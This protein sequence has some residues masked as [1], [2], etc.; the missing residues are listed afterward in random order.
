MK[1][2]KKTIFFLITAAFLV[3]AGGAYALEP[4]ALLGE[5]RYFV[6]SERSLVRA[7]F[8]SRHEFDGGFTSDLTRGELWAL[9]KWFDVSVQ[10]IPFYQINTSHEE[11]SSS[12]TEQTSTSTE[13]STT[14]QDAT[15]EDSSQT[16][17]REHTP[18]NQQSWGVELVR[19]T[20]VPSAPEE[21]ER[22]VAVAVLDTGVEQTHPDIAGRVQQCIDFTRSSIVTNN[23]DDDN[24]HGTHIAGILAGTGGADGEGV[25]GVAPHADIFAYKVCRSDGSC[26]ADDVSAGI[27][28]GIENGADI[29]VLGLGGADK[30]SLV[31]DALRLAEENNVL[32][33]ASAGN[34][35]ADDEGIGYPA[36]YET[37]IGVGALDS[38]LNVPEW[39][40]RGVN[41][42]DGIIQE[43]EIT[44]AGPGVNIESLWNNNEYRYLSGTSVAVPFVGGLASLIWDGS[45]TS[46]YQ[47]LLDITEDVWETGI[48]NAT[49]FGAPRLVE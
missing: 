19:G 14:T 23:C 44:F 26:W 29:I 24:G 10:Q 35:G 5:G 45:A 34:N 18:D 37:A 2:Y 36:A 31:E 43:E 38:D 41:N 11:E 47:A 39:S 8:G 9:D 3:V 30:S 46:T 49:G 40:S 28:Y 33:V 32:V 4:S 6:E 27:R 25:I 48:D 16:I 42:G 15:D 1:T 7:L 22:Q 13:K 17:D 20:D 12:T 21:E